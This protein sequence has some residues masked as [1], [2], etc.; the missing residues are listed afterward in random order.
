MA[1]LAFMSVSGVPAVC[2]TQ[3]RALVSRSQF[4]EERAVFLRER[5]AGFYGASKTLRLHAL[6]GAGPGIYSIAN[7]VTIVPFARSPPDTLALTASSL[8][9]RSSSR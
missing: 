9:A 8:D 3:A 6:T 4:I 2:L 5:G 7:T 1:F